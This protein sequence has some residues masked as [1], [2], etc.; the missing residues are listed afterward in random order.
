M[1]PPHP[2][3]T[4]PDPPPYPPPDLQASGTAP[5]MAMWTSMHIT[6]PQLHLLAQ[7]LRRRSAQSSQPGSPAVVSPSLHSPRHNG[8]HSSASSSSPLASPRLRQQQQQLERHSSG[9][10]RGGGAFAAAAAEV[11]GGSSP[12]S[13]KVM[14]PNGELRVSVSG[15]MLVEWLKAVIATGSDVPPEQQKL[16]CSGRQLE[17]G[18]SLEQCGVVPGAVVHVVVRLNGF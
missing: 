1:I 17:D 2:A 11:Q 9:S 13:V 15:T 6:P 5:P 10:I 8:F 16:I 7:D 3:D 4:H 18:L 14:A 12:F